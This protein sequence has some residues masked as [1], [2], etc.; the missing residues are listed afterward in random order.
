MSR[1]KCIVQNNSGYKLTVVIPPAGDD[2]LR[3]SDWTDDNGSTVLPVGT[4]ISPGQKLEVGSISNPSGVSTAHWGW[5]YFYSEAKN[6]YIQLY[7]YIWEEDSSNNRY[8]LGYFDK[9]SNK[10]DPQPSGVILGKVTYD[11]ST[12]EATYNFSCTQTKCIIK[13]NSGYDLTV[14][15][16]PGSDGT[17][18]AGSGHW[19]WV[20]EPDKTVKN[21][22]EIQV[23]ILG[24]PNKNERDY[25]GWIYFYSVAKR[26]YIQLYIKSTQAGEHECSLGYF[27]VKS[28]K[29]EPQPDGI[30]GSSSYNNKNQVATYN[31][32]C[33]QTKCIIKNNSGKDLYVGVPTDKGMQ[34]RGEQML[35]VLSPDTRISS[36]EEVEVG[37]I[38][39]PDKSEGDYHGW[40][41][42]L[43]KRLNKYIQLYIR[44]SNKKENYECNMGLFSK[45]SSEDEPQPSG[46]LVKGKYNPATNEAKY[47]FK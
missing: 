8:S 30:L 35:G 10:D 28:S 21:K 47:I 7:I 42:F 33:T 19:N 36:G 9:N 12:N 25:Y 23:G 5:I 4:E 41:Y 40:I 44:S 45:N 18:I 15:A 20:A 43:S 6:S 2:R 46:I 27:N 3:G 11:S 16:P 32:S 24:N 39:N 26:R 13:N 29:S 1:T 14:K 31:F 22:E 17:C 37:R 34:F 38:G